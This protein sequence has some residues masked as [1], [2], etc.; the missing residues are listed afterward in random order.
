VLRATLALLTALGLISVLAVTGLSYVLGAMIARRLRL[1]R[2]ALTAFGGGDYDHRIPRAGSDEIG[3]LFLAFNQMADQIPH[4]TGAIK[5]DA[6]FHSG[7]PAALAEADC[8][9]DATV[10]FKTG[11]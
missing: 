2:D 11:S 4:G 6:A 7:L 5:C 3:Q 9:D 8:A 1:L 10:I